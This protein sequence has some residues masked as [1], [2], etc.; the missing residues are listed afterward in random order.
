MGDELWPVDLSHLFHAGEETDKGGL[1]EKLSF[2]VEKLL[3]I[4]GYS[5][6]SKCYDRSSGV[7]CD[8]FKKICHL[9]S[10]FFCCSYRESRSYGLGALIYDLLE[11][12][13][14]SVAPTT[15]SMRSSH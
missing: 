5:K 11:L 10:Y 4:S 2:H 13:H 15:D 14:G 7:S 12:E 9:F 1:L 3:F 6:H 8:F